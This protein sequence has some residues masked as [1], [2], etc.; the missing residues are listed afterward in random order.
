[1]RKD[2]RDFRYTL[3]FVSSAASRT[4]TSTL[5]RF[6]LCILLIANKRSSYKS[7]TI[8]VNYYLEMLILLIDNIPLLANQFHIYALCCTALFGAEAINSDADW[9]FRLLYHG[10][11]VESFSSAALF[12]GTFSRITLLSIAIFTYLELSYLR[13]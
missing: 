6:F 13:T 8:N 11:L 7:D 12:L 1:M 5:L 2:L 10:N 3:I 9:D 4:S